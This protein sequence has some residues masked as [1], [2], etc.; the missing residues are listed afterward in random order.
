MGCLEEGGGQ[1]GDEKGLLRVHARLVEPPREDAVEE[2]ARGLEGGPGLP[3]AAPPVL[4]GPDRPVLGED[5]TGGRG[6]AEGP[7]GE[8]DGG[9]G[10][11]VGLGR[12]SRRGGRGGLG[13][14][15]HLAQTAADGGDARRRGGRRLGRG[16]HGEGRRLEIALAEVEG[17]RGRDGR[18]GRRSG[19]RSGLGH[20]GGRR[21]VL[22][23]VAAAKKEG[24]GEKGREN[25]AKGPK[26]GR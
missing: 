25:K 16:L 17:W 8:D 3:V 5:G 22:A 21:R 10:E 6:Q 23:A 20:V 4:E 13:G 18:R 24:G 2:D 9:E 14:A 19:R 11:V 12:R 7:A 15:G 26:R 1:D